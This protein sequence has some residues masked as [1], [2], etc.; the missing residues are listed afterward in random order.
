VSDRSIPGV[1]VLGYNKLTCAP[2]NGTGSL[3]QH[4]DKSGSTTSH[5]VGQG[6]VLHA[7]HP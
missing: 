6:I 4:C 5:R 3:L 7:D 1:S 2:V